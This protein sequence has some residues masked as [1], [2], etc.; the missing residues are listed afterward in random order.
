MT[1]YICSIQLV[2]ALSK[3]SLEKLTLIIKQYLVWFLHDDIF[4]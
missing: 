2:D 3:H 4:V 1:C